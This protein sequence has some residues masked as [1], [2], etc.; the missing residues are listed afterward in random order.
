[1]TGAVGEPGAGRCRPP[2]Q[3]AG[4]GPA[5]Q[6]ALGPWHQRRGQGREGPGQTG[7]SVQLRSLRSLA[8]R[9][10]CLRGH[11][12]GQD[13]SPRERDSPTLLDLIWGFAAH[14]ALVRSDFVMEHLRFV[15]FFFFFF[16]TLKPFF[17]TLKR[18]A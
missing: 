3:P 13:P 5:I 7:P 11:P 2:C 18:V 1:M 17:F 12:Q 6:R 9:R 16:F 8:E 15:V 14:I 10:R 4:A